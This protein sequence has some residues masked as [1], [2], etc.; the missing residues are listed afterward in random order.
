MTFKALIVDKTEDDAISQA[1]EEIEEEIDS[2]ELGELDGVSNGSNGTPAA[3]IS[4]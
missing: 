4:A 1:V 2:D 3:F